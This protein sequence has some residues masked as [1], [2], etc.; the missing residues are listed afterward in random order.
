MDLRAGRRTSEMKP[1]PAFGFYP[2]FRPCPECRGLMLTATPVTRRFLKGPLQRMG[3][4]CYCV[5]CNTRYRA[6]SRLAFVWVAWMG[7]LGRW[8]WWQTTTLGLT[9]RSEEPNP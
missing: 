5:Q 6:T 9:L 1:T 8:I 4:T 3:I 2:A 7:N